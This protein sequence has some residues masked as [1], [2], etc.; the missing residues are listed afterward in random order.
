[1]MEMLSSFLASRPKRAAVIVLTLIVVIALMLAGIAIG[2][3]HFGQ[4]PYPSDNLPIKL[5]NDDVVF[6]M[7]TTEIL[8]N[9]S[10]NYTGMK[11]AFRISQVNG[12]VQIAYP[13]GN[14]SQLSAHANATMSQWLF[15]GTDN[16]NINITDSTGDGSFDEGDTILFNFEPLRADTIYTMGLFATADIGAGSAGW[17]MERSFAIHDGKLYAWNSNYLNTERPW[18]A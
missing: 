12:Y 14:Q 5:V 7:D 15:Q 8:E 11:I 4:A 13:F 16:V 10:F 17:E 3:S 18:F 1:M 6:T 2:L 9:S